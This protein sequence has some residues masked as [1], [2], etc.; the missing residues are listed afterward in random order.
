MAHAIEDDLRD[1]ALAHGIVARF[2]DLR[3]G[4]AIH[5]AGQI[6]LGPFEPEW[7][8][9]RVGQPGKGDG[10]IE[11]PRAVGGQGIDRHWLHRRRRAGWPHPVG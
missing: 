8:R 3:R 11:R 2:I 9:R 10:G 5:G 1:G 7:P 6:R 4:Q